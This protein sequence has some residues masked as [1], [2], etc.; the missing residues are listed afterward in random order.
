MFLV[1]LKHSWCSCR[2][3]EVLLD[4]YKSVYSEGEWSWLRIGG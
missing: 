2:E 1:D 4:K 3:R